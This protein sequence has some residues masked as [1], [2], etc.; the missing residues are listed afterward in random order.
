MSEAGNSANAIDARAA[1]WL[2]RLDAG[3]NRTEAEL[4]AW[5]AEDSRHR[6]AF[7]RAQAAWNGLDRLGILAN[8]GAVVAQP[9]RDSYVSRRRLLVAGGG[10][11]TIAASAAAAGFLWL[12]GERIETPRGEIRRVPLDDGSLLA[13]NTDSSLAVAMKPASR[14]ITVGKGEVWFK[15]AKDRKRPFVVAVGEV[16]VRA[17]G[18]AF[19]V[20]RRD[21]GADVLVTEG[22]V[23]TW[24]VAGGR[25]RRVAAGSKVF[26][27]DIAGPS[28][29]VA[30]PSQIDRTL[31]WRNGEIALDGETL[32]DAAEEFNRYNAKRI[33]IDPALAEKRLV[34][35]FHTDEPE[36]FAHA[37]A[38]TL[39]ATVVASDDEIHL[40]PK[41][42]R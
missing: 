6:G 33:T 27:S 28:Q 19:S 10:A 1:E 2:V 38:M 17:V 36:T 39:G 40:A 11:A 42:E 15:V 30:A 31:A 3:G 13:V 9:M 32:G 7:L 41:A 25:V 8:G 21:A 5:L 16:R 35:W 34:G 23:E 26:V 20:R 18:T 22:V 24:S 12:G 37:A 29:V 4:E 14:E